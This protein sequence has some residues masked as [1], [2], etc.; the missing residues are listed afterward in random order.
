MF[1]HIEK[2]RKTHLGKKHTKETKEKI[3]ESHKKRNSLK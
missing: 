1:I 3:S 2:Y